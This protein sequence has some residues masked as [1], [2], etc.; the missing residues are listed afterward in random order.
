VTSDWH[1][2]GKPAGFSGKGHKGMGLGNEFD[3]HNKPLPSGW[4]AGLPIRD[5]SCLD[6]SA[7]TLKT[8]I[9]Q[10]ETSIAGRRNGCASPNF[11]FKV[12]FH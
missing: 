1:R 9:T 5:L 8:S 2:Y 10:L 4:V 3:T 6:I 12:C 11:P 7:C